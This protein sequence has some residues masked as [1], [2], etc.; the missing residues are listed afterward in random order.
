MDKRIFL[1]DTVLWIVSIGLMLFSILEVFSAASTLSYKSGDYMSPIYGH[2][3]HLVM[4]F[5]V[6]WVVH[7]IPSR[8]FKLASFVLPLSWLLLIGVM[9]LVSFVNGAMRWLFATELTKICTII[10]IALILSRMQEERS[11]NR[12]AFKYVLEI[13]GISVCLIGPENLSTALI[14][15][16]TAIFM[17]IV[18]RI[19]ESR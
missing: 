4:G 19:P 17:M 12:A 9:L 16:I 5:V 7:L 10:S 15:V 11:A 14:L 1:G 18:G 13:L 6:M 2:I 3:G 8:N